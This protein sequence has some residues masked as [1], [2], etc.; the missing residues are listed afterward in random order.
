VTVEERGKD[1]WEQERARSRY[2][3]LWF[4]LKW[5]GLMAGLLIAFLFVMWRSGSAVEFAA[6]RIDETTPPRYRVL[7]TVKN[8]ATGQPVSWPTAYDDPKGRPPHYKGE[9]KSD[10]TFELRTVAEPHDVIVTSLGFHPARVRVGKSWY[11]WM[12]AG[13][14]RVVVLL[15]P[16]AAR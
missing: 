2:E 16:E 3:F 12:P 13:E 8:A 15:T 5:G 7:G 1:F 14:E 10:G 4:S 9:P 6:T 11:L